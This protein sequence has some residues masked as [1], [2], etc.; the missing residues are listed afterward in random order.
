[1]ADISFK[2]EVFEGPL[3][4]LLSLIEKN[5]ID[6]YDI[7]IH[8][9]TDQYLEYISEAH[10]QNMELTAS[11]IEMASRLMYIKSCSLL[12]RED[13]EEDP[14]A[15]LE[16]MLIQYAKYK[17]VA[18]F[19]KE[20]YIGHRIFFR[21][22]VPEGLPAP[23]DKDRLPTAEDL[24]KAYEE[25]LQRH[26]RRQPIPV[27]AFKNLVAT[28]FVTVTSRIIHILKNT[29]KSG[30]IKFISLFS[31]KSDRSE[32]V[33]TFLAVLELMHS[34]RIDVT[35]SDVKNSEIILNKKRQ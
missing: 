12:P 30:K 27:S 11:F 8:L 34:G 31:K 26:N 2:L 6:I 1:M 21:E 10:R 33:A 18:G 4:L 5:K 25:T 35:D 22:T 29:F 17:Q 13:D 3:D 28:R 9:L 32:I 19:L 20:N 24:Q 16:E 23:F 15:T 7:E 14:K